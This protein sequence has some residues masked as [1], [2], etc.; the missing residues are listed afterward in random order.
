MDTGGTL[1][2]SQGTLGTS[3]S[4]GYQLGYV[5]Q[6]LTDTVGII[7]QLRVMGTSYSHLKQLG[8]YMC[9]LFQVLAKVRA[10]GTSQGCA[11]QLQGTCLIRYQLQ[12]GYCGTLYNVLFFCMI[13]YIRSLFCLLFLCTLLFP[14]R[15]LLIVTQFIIM[16]T[17]DSFIYNQ[18]F[19]ILLFCQY[20]YPFMVQLWNTLP[21]NAVSLSTVG[22]YL[23]STGSLL[24]VT[25]PLS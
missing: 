24:I 8:L 12:L 5:L 6:V 4:Y 22:Q 20:S 14:L 3:C 18:C 10:V 19:Q 1:G 25:F 9:V 11:I 21:I 17:S 7:Y 23:I 13:F 15:P 16:I 2:T